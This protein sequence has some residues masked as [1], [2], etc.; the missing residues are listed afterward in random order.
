M[1]LLLC[2]TWLREKVQ[3]VLLFHDINVTQNHGSMPKG[4][5]KSRYGKNSL[6]C[7]VLKTF[8]NDAP[9]L[10]DG[11]LKHTISLYILH[12]LNHWEIYKYDNE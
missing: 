12:W 8:I 9:F 3:F 4:A 10:K 1:F 6:G 5:T 7:T 2:D 11:N